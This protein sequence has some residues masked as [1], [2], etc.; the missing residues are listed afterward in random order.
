MQSYRLVCLVMG[1]YIF[2]LFGEVVG[3]TLTPEPQLNSSSPRAVV[4]YPG[5][6]C[7]TNRRNSG[8]SH[9]RRDAVL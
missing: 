7:T 3:M 4:V 2:G 9:C 8:K 6:F 1:L 5:Q